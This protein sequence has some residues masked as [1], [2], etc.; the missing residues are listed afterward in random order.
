MEALASWTRLARMD[1]GFDGSIS[2]CQKKIYI[3]QIRD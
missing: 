1:G 3:E 2:V